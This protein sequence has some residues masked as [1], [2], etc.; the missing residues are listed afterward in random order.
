MHQNREKKKVV[1]YNRLKAILNLSDTSV[2]ETE[3]DHRQNVTPISDFNVLS[4]ITFTS[5][6]DEES[7]MLE[8]LRSRLENEFGPSYHRTLEDVDRN[9]KF[10]KKNT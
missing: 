6:E 5:T 3:R 8:R 4:K 10:L 2:T 9:Y 7:V 1:E